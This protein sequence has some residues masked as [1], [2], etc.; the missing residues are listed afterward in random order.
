MFLRILKLSLH[1]VGRFVSD[2]PKI[3]SKTH[4]QVSLYDRNISCLL[5]ADDVVLLSTSAN[6]LQNCLSSLESYC[7]QWGLTVNLDKTKIMIFNKSGHLHRNVNIYFKGT[8]VEVVDKYCYLGVCFQIS[9]TF[10]LATKQLK[11]KALKALF[12]LT[13]KLPKTNV[14]IGFKLFNS[15]ILPVVSYATEIWCPYLFEKL[16]ETNMDQ[17]FENMDT[18]NIHTRFCKCLLGVP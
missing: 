6:G 16:N 5:Y 3:F 9:G 15:L 12:K 14:S 17:I 10:K 1:S 4:D 11:E 13:K 18:E 8:L 7:Q 2:L